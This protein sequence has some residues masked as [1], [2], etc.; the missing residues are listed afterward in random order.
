[1]AVVTGVSQTYQ[2]GGTSGVG[3]ENKEALQDAIFDISPTG[4]SVL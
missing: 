1:M 2:L 4:V 3:R